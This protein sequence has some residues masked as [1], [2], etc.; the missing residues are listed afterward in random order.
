MGFG[1]GASIGVKVA[2][3]DKTVF[4]IAGDGSFGMNCNEFATAVK[5]N[6]PIKIIVI[7]KYLSFLLQ[8]EYC[9]TISANNKP[10]KKL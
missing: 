3:P 2:N 7:D 9:F 8:N 5:Y 10:K 1:L 4:N 6:I